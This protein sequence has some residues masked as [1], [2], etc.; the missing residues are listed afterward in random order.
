MQWAFSTPH[1]VP[2]LGQRELA[3]RTTS[4][5][6]R[7]LNEGMGIDQIVLHYEHMSGESLRRTMFPAFSELPCII[8]KD[9]IQQYSR[10]EEIHLDTRSRPIV[11]GSKNCPT[12]VCIGSVSA[13]I[14][15]YLSLSPPC[16]PSPQSKTQPIPA[17]NEGEENKDL[18]SRRVTRDSQGSSRSLAE[19]PAPPDCWGPPV[20]TLGRARHPSAVRLCPRPPQPWLRVRVRPPWATTARDAAVPPGSLLDRAPRC[21]GSYCVRGSLIQAGQIHRRRST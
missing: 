6:F 12:N 9:L 15:V 19:S 10:E 2:T 18:V 4:H 20:P 14:N 13:S 16:H 17:G 21:R 8:S 5:Q 3:I 7:S 11:G 1:Y